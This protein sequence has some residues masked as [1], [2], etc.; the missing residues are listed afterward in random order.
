MA[1][2]TTLYLQLIERRIEMLRLLAA[3]LRQSHQA[4]AELNLAGIYEATLQQ[5]NLCAGIRFLDRELKAAE[6][7][8]SPDTEQFQHWVR[9]LGA[10]EAEVRHLNRIQAGLIRRSRRSVNVMVN[11]LA[12]YSSTYEAPAPRTTADIPAGVG[13]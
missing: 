5:E 2:E 7:F 6:G 11:F 3:A 1:R 10:A 12:N 13:A 4:I 9:Q 8:C